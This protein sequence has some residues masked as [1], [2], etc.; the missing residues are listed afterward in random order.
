MICWLDG[1]FLLSG[2]LLT[3]VRLITLRL[4]DCPCMAV[5]LSAGD[6]FG[7]AAFVV[8]EDVPASR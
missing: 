8:S 7:F 3:G 4:D 1:L 6:G 2:E 5:F